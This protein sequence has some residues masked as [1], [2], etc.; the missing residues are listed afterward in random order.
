MG[1]LLVTYLISSNCVLWIR[2]I[3][4]VIITHSHA[5]AIGGL[6]DLRDWTNNVQPS[7]PI[8]VAERDF[9]DAIEALI[10]RLQ[11]FRAAQG[12]LRKFGKSDQGEHFSL[13]DAPDGS[14]D[15]KRGPLETEGDRSEA[16]CFQLSYDG[17]RR[18]RQRESIV[19]YKRLAA[20]LAS[21][22][23]IV[24]NAW[25]LERERLNI[26]VGFLKFMF[27]LITCFVSLNACN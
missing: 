12:L 20:C 11:Q 6:D 19:L 26:R 8:Y 18:A 1:K 9:E 7:V 24:L 3:D 22:R 21:Y 10:G 17:L 2:T 14:R 27:L 13:Y 25:K 5:D 16:G 23:H 15:N 4:A